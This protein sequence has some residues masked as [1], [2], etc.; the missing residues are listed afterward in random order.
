M[1]APTKALLAA[2]SLLSLAPVAL[3]GTYT[4]SYVG[5]TI[6]RNDGSSLVGTTVYDNQGSPYFGGSGY[7][8]N[9]G[10]SCSGCILLLPLRQLVK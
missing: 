5:T 4:V 3:G 9:F 6:Y 8:F 2:F 7:D 10:V 1:I